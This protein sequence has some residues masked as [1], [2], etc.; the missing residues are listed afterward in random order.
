MIYV[1][2]ISN[3]EYFISKKKLNYEIIFK[4]DEKPEYIHSK[5]QRDIYA[6]KERERV[7]KNKQA[8]REY[9]KNYYNK[10]HKNI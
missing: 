10:K 4:C 3:I 6:K 2:K 9:R 1:Y 5:K 8:V 7:E